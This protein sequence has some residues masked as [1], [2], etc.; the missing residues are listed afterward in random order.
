MNERYARFLRR[1]P[2]PWAARAEMVEFARERGPRAAARRYGAGLRTVYRLLRL[3]GAGPLRR[4]PRRRGAG[5]YRRLVKSSPDPWRVRREMVACAIRHG[6]EEAAREFGAGVTTV[7][8]WLR[9]ARDGPWRRPGPA[10]RHLSIAEKEAIIRARIERPGLGAARLKAEF[11][12]PHGVRQIKALLREH[13]L[14][15]RWRRRDFARRLKTAERRL[16]MARLELGLAEAEHDLGKGPAGPGGLMA[17]VRRMLVEQDR[18]E[19]WRA[20]AERQRR[21]EEERK[22]RRGGRGGG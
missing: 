2:D 6:V 20:R 14:A 1:A 21:R 13:G 11:G 3:A 17:A 5:R 7:R 19:K 8:R 9:R 4:P 18:V 10:R 22:G 15:R 12:L 16:A